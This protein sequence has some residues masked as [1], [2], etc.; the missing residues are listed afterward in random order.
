MVP[1]WP[2]ASQMISPLWG[3]CSY[4]KSTAPFPA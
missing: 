3:E 2:G 1:G 4:L